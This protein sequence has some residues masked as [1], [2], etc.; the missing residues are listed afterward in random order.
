ML[1]DWGFELYA[2]NEFRKAT[3]IQRPG[4]YGRVEKNFF[5][6]W[7]KKG[8]MYAHYDVAPKRVFA[9]LDF[10]GSVGRDLAP[11][12]AINDDRCLAKYLPKVVKPLSTQDAESIHQATN[13]LKITLCKRSDSSCRESDA[14]TFIF[15]IYHHKGFYSFH[16][17][18]EAY[19]M[20]FR[21]TAPFEIYGM[22]KKP[23]WING[24]NKMRPDPQQEGDMVI[25]EGEP[26]SWIET[27]MLYITSLS[28]KT[29]GQKYH[30][31]IDDILFITFGVEDSRTA[32][33]DIVAGDLFVDL[34]L[35]STS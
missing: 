13:S 10:D 27:E 23:I 2:E 16:S 12:A 28:W 26:K 4:K 22:S 25:A 24:R 19:V 11:K 29:Q 34:G 30:G 6:F 21:Q 14:N 9:K 1:M 8:A 3:E 33:I 18:Y 5:V 32:G 7:D 20:A 15:T 17:I 35:C 31:Y